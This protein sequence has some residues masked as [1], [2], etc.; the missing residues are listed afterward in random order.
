M[1]DVELRKKKK[2]IF[3]GEEKKKKKSKIIMESQ[4]NLVLTYFNMLPDKPLWREN[5]IKYHIIYFNSL[6]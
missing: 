4:G 1:C 3:G 2:K 6:H 5:I